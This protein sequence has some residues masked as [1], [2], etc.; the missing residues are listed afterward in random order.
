M[1]G[2]PGLLRAPELRRFLLAGAFNTALSY[3][4]F[5]LLDRWLPYVVAYLLAYAIGIGVQF[6]LFS[7]YVY[8]SRPDLART[9]A[10]PL[11][12]LVIAG[13][14]SGVLWLT[15]QVSGWPSSWAGLVAIAAQVPVA[16]M[17][18]RWWFAHSTAL[19]QGW[20][21]LERAGVAASLGGAAMFVT[22]GL[23]TL[24]HSGFRRPLWDQFRSYQMLLETPF[25]GNVFVAENGHRPIFPNLLKLLDLRLDGGNQEVLLLCGGL[26]A[27][28]VFGLW[29]WTLWRE[30]T[31]PPL[32]RAAGVLAGAMTIFWL[33]NARMLLHGN[34][35]VAV[36]WVLGWLT[37]GLVA[38]A[39]S[40][41][42]PGAIGLAALSLVMG[43]FGFGNGPVIGCTL[44]L[45]AV[46]LRRPWRQVA[47]LAASFVVVLLFYTV[48]LPGQGTASTALALRPAENVAVSLR[49]LSGAWIQA[50]L[51]LPDH[52]SGF[53]R[54]AMEHRGVGK[55]LIVSADW[56]AR[57]PGD[58]MARQMQTAL[59]VGAAGVA[60]LLAISARTLSHPVEANATRVLGLGLGWFALGTAL[61]IGLS[62][63]DYFVQFG[64]QIFAERY[65]PWSCVF[66]F[67]LMLALA[68]TLP[69]RWAFF[70][71]PAGAIGVGVIALALWPSH[72]IWAGWAAIVDRQSRI[73]TLA[74]AQDENPTAMDAALAIPGEA[75]TLKTVQSLRRAGSDLYDGKCPPAAIPPA[76][77]SLTLQWA[78]PSEAPPTPSLRR[79]QG[80]WSGPASGDRVWVRDADGVCVG[81]GELAYYEDLDKHPWLGRRT[82]IDALVRVAGARMPLYVQ[83]VAADGSVLAAGTVERAP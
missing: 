55:W 2:L 62:R 44:L 46:L 32:W 64:R 4:V 37:C 65:L 18:T 42:I 12:H 60:L 58:A 36:Y 48:L 26:F 77:S 3:A 19:Q 79:L 50:W 56:L 16:F 61:L 49:W 68:S 83:L 72:Q 7:R 28:I 54:A 74:L 22:T 67:G 24:Y 39:H 70:T 47:L 5:V 27:S 38:L 11:L 20:T 33:G 45:M 29:A 13:F 81:R 35:S 63:L 6:T 76:V 34:E 23:L 75:S 73:F 8:R 17:L 1:S 9:L 71:A 78:D 43:C 10:Y 69:N 30:R 15:V 52:P 41:R 80:S 82:G 53:M 25:P 66:W 59:W 31:L 21:W 14:G 51:G 40:T 57:G